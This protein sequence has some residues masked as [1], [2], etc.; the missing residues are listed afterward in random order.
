MTAEQEKR[1]RGRPRSDEPGSSVSAWLRAG[2]HDRL[3]AL[4]KQEQKT[5]SALV[6]ELVTRRIFQQ[7]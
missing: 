7:K 2:D 1:L 5:I 6:R 3:I 4:A